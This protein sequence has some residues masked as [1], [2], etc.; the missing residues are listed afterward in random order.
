MSKQRKAY[1]FKLQPNREQEAAF[2]QFSGNSR[3]V[4]NALLGWAR[5]MV[6]TTGESVVSRAQ[7]CKRITALKAAHEWLKR[8]HSQTRQSAGDDLVAG[9]QRF[10]KK[11]GGFPKFKSK[12][13]LKHS[14]R[15]KQGV[16]LDRN[17][18]YLPKIG[19]VK[20]RKS[21]GVKGDIKTATI[22]KTVSGW[23]V[24]LSCVVA[25]EPRPPNGK[26]VGV[27]FGL[28]HFATLST[29]EKIANPK[30][31]EKSQR[32]LRKLSRALSRKKKG[33]S[34]RTK[35][36]IKRAK[37]HEKVANLRKDF[38]HKFTSRLV[39][40]N[41]AMGLETLN[42]KGMLKNRRLAKAIASVSWYETA[43]QIEYKAIW[44][45][46][47][48]VRVDRFFPSSKR[49]HCCQVKVDG[50]KLS[51]RSITCPHCGQVWDR[52]HHAAINLENV[53]IGHMETLNACGDERQS[54]PL[55]AVV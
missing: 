42:I 31:Y 35:A 52:D 39:S 18:I 15:Y 40:E 25:I 33:S 16:Q 24:S 19:W 2:S 7:F 29:G 54:S 4:Y 45:G 5:E 6:Q 22:S 53:A 50:L 32:K 1:K 13:N 51:Q 27:D 46:R 37:H 36:K 9:Y 34:N 28:S 10:F 3:F 30:H 41:Q 11:L 20:F 49:V 8:S 48:V 38:L 14:F 26:A 17:D 47:E 21:Q 55:L 12:K 23:Y 43:R 44:Y